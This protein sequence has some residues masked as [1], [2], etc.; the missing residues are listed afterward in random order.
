MSNWQPGDPALIAVNPQDDAAGVNGLRCVLREYVGD[1]R[2]ANYKVL[3]A[4]LV[5][6]DGLGAIV[7]EECLRK[8]YDPFEPGSWE[9]IKDIFT[10]KE[11]EVIA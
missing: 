9:D 2:G 6:I 5:N 4:W 3:N 1:T 7:E 8:P 10:P 11:L